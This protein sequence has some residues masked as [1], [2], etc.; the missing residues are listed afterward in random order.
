MTKRNELG[1]FLPN[2]Q[3]EPLIWVKADASE[4][5]D[6]VTKQEPCLE[7]KGG[8]QLVEQH[9][10]TEPAFVNQSEVGQPYQHNLPQTVSLTN[11][12]GED[13]VL[14]APNPKIWK[15]VEGGRKIAPHGQRRSTCSK[16]GGQLENLKQRYCKKCAAE[17]KALS[18]QRQN[19][20]H[21]GLTSNED[22]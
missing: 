17:A 12:L 9:Q 18:R 21:L 16:C 4:E 8:V 13:V 2:D 11:D 14:I 6:H 20:K 10:L 1:Q 7:L 15:P 19:V 5:D 3:L 22:V